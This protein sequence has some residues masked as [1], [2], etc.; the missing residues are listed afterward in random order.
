MTTRQRAH[1]S[2]RLPAVM[3]VRMLPP[4]LLLLA[5]T[6]VLAACGPSG[7][8]A[9]SDAG[10]PGDDAASP[11]ETCSSTVECSGG[12]VCDPSTGSCTADPVSCDEH[13]DCGPAAFCSEG[14]V[15]EANATGGP[16]SGDTGC[17]PGE[18]CTGGFCGC[19]GDQFVAEAVPPNVLI[20]LDQSGS[21]DNTVGGKSKWDIAVDA[22]DALVTDLGT[23]VRFGLVLYPGVGA[24]CTP[25]A[26][27]VDVA[28]ATG[29][30]I[31]SALASSA[32]GGQTPIG[33]TLAPLVDYPGLEDP[34]H[35]GYVLLITDGE[36]TC[37]GDG[38]AAVTALR[39]QTPEIKTFV[40]GF[41][42][43]VD[44]AALNDMAVA[45]G[46][47]LPGD[48]KYYQADDAASLSAAFADIAG[49]VLSCSYALSGSPASADDLH[50]YF[51]GMAIPRDPGQS[52][53]WDY[54]LDTDR[55]T[56]YGPA[57]EALQSGTIGD[58]VIVHGCPV[59][60]E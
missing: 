48:P 16:C 24:Q 43:G 11:A 17:I 33:D 12:Q 20:V 52:D 25:G 8:A 49:E 39:N 58:L 13:P 18:S 57:C 46:T 35:P 5:L 56:F 10:G 32:P 21:M 7:G 26:V 31:T 44:P 60:V 4:N 15:C 36:E 42:G 19:E 40:V 2:A 54:D 14:G 37:D 38:V 45:G 29:A 41:G 59:N 47:E 50:V 34:Q 3:P 51:D 1:S 23:S 28:T 9:G 53:G 6:L 55:I 27:S 22:V 30:A